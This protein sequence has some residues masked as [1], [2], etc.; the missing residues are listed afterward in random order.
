MMHER[1][2]PTPGQPEQLSCSPDQADV[3]RPVAEN[4]TPN[5]RRFEVAL[6][7]YGELIAAG[8]S[9]ALEKRADVD[10]GTARCIAHVLGRSLGRDSALAGFGRTGEGD[11]ESLREE[12]LA[13]HSAEGVSA[14][15]RGLIDWLG[16][17]LIRQHHPEARAATYQ[18]V[19]PP[20]LTNIL[21]PTGVEVG[22]WYFTVHVPGTSGSAQIA[23]LS[24]TLT[25]LAADRDTALRVF[26][27]LPDVN[28]MSGDIMEDFHLQYIGVYSTVEDALHELAEVDERERDVIEYAEERQLIIEQVTPD[29]DAL[30]E[31]IADGFDL[32]EHE[33]RAYVFSK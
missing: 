6:R 2:T 12:Y 9:T 1:P 33:G 27:G 19:Y 16:T 28:A 11:Y 5:W 29:Y 20:R 15:T 21:V 32:V 3:L 31:Q 22:D 17:Y 8:L 4:G 10:Q 13:L 18:E 30:R 26:L 7:R 24:E 25:E 23:E 14:S